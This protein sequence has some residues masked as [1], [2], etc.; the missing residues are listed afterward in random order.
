RSETLSVFRH[1]PWRNPLLL[2]GTIGAQLVHIAA[3]FTPG[4]RDVLHI[5]PVSLTLWAALLGLALVLLVAMELQK[6]ARAAPR[7]RLRRAHATRR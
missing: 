4:L 5:E 3:M 2:F 1:D 7:W 6:A